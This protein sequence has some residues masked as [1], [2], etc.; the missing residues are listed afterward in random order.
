MLLFALDR[1]RV[2][3]PSRLR[4]DSSNQPTKDCDG[5]PRAYPLASVPAEGED[6]RGRACRADYKKRENIESRCGGASA[7]NAGLNGLHGVAARKKCGNVLRPGR[8][9]GKRNRD[10][11]DNQ[12]RQEN[13]LAESLHRRHVGG[14]HGDIEADAHKSDRRRTESGPQH[15]GMPRRRHADRHGETQ[16]QQTRAKQQQIPR[17]QGAGKNAE[18]RYG[19]HF[20][21]APYSPF[22]VAHY[23]GRQAEAGAPKDGNGQQFAGVKRERDS[24]LTIEGAERE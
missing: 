19:K 1:L 14:K 6:S 4:R 3:A 2:N 5:N 20:V 12:H 16:L 24:F 9:T 17:H 18:C 15:Q 8:Q 23:T 11:A 13:A 7:R 10:P 21:A 22:A